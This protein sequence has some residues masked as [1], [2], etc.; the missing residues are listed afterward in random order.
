MFQGCDEP[1]LE[2]HRRRHVEQHGLHL[3]KVVRGRR[4]LQRGFDQVSML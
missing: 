4:R 1:R 3:E 2:L